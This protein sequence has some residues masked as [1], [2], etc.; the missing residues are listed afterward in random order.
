MKL[1]NCN[2]EQF[3]TNLNGR[4]V[5][6]FGAGHKM[7]NIERT[8]NRIEHLEDYIAFFVDNDRKKQGTR[9]DYLGHD[10]VIKSADELKTVSPKDYVC[11]I[12]CTFFIEIYEELKN[13][14]ELRDMECYM[15]DMVCSHPDLDLETF[16]TQ[17]LENGLLKSWKQTLAGLHLKDRHKGKRCFLIG[18]GPSLTVEDLELLKDEI[19]FAANRIYMLFDKT[20][21]RPTYY[22]CVDYY[23]YSSDHRKI[24]RMEAALKFVPVENA[25]AAGEIYK[26][27]SYYNRVVSCVEDTH[28]KS[29]SGKAPKFSCDAETVVYDGRTVLYDAIQW[30]VYMGF[31]EIYLLGVDGAYKFEALENGTVIETDYKK[32][33]FDASYEE[34]LDKIA[35]EVYAMHA[36]FQKAKEICEPMGITIK[37]ATRGGKLEVFARI[38]LEAL[39][40]T[41]GD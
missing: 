9:L 36:A 8:A 2:A 27:I 23:G 22:F 35:P 25:M 11:L 32:S 30:A 41:Q 28:E 15:Y 26:G 31:S 37:N 14:P 21:W 40:K 7:A 34:G 39:I 38:S 4:K 6:C 16:F 17:K 33:H 29:G 1:K 5:V 12:T 19:T 13:M 18:N 10:F 3:I 24:D 20:T